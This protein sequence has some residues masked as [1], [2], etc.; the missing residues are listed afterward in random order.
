MQT[1]AQKGSYE[2]QYEIHQAAKRAALDRLAHRAFR[3]V[4]RWLPQDAGAPVLEIGP[5]DGKTLAVFLAE[6][7][8][9][10]R[11]IEADRGLAESAIGAGLPVTHC[12]ADDT[13]KYLAERPCQFAAIYCAHVLEHVDVP[14]QIDFVRAIYDALAPGGRFICEVPSATSALASYARYV[15]WTHRCLFT[16]ASL[17][18]VLSA[19]GLDDIEVRPTL[20]GVVS[21]RPFGLDLP[22]L[23]VQRTLSAISQW[24]Y[25]LHLLAELGE[26]GL[27]QPVT[28]AMLASG[29]KPSTGPSAPR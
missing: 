2:G 29:R 17:R 11:A 6:G 16:S 21:R 25:R 9:N 13:V 26:E 10:T 22:M 18:F 14:Q 12:P 1:S 24:T 8:V 4:R 15:D 5:G 19:A 23:I 7:Y 27:R 3:G 20:P 28:S